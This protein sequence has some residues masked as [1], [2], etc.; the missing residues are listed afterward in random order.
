MYLISDFE[1]YM[2]KNIKT[3]KY[4]IH[5]VQWLYLLNYISDIFRR[6][7]YR[8]TMFHGFVVESRSE[9]A[10]Q[11]CHL[12]IGHQHLKDGFVT[13]V[14][15]GQDMWHITVFAQPISWF[16][17]VSCRISIPVSGSMVLS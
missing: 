13:F 11:W 12:G 16:H 2:V 10:K 6:F 5:N 17:D 8:N 9:R 1:Y 4:L 7:A 15:E 3:C 14:Q